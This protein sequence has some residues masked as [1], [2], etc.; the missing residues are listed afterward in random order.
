MAT[1]YGVVGIFLVP[2]VFPFRRVSVRAVGV[3]VLLECLVGDG[4]EFPVAPDLESALRR[5][6]YGGVEV[7]AGLEPQSGPD[8]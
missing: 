5:G 4:P 1:A 8:R 7:G 6:D 2:W 3:P